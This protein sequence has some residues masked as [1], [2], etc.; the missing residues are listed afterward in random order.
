MVAI[1][2]VTMVAVAQHVTFVKVLSVPTVVV[3]VWVEI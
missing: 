1:I 2:Q 3:N